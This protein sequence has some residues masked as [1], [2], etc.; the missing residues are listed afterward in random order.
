[1]SQS[2]CLDL[3]GPDTHSLNANVQT[4]GFRN[5]VL[6]GLSRSRKE[7]HCKYFYDERGSQLF[8]QICELPEYYPTRT[9]ASI[10][11]QNADAIGQRIG[12][13]AVLVEYGSGSST[14]TR[15]LLDH[16]VDQ[17]AYLPVDISDEHLLRT[18]DQL[19][20]DYPNLEIDPIVADF[21]I[22]FDLPDAY[23]TTPV[24]VYFPGSTIGNLRTDAAVNLLS[25][26][27]KQCHSGGGLVIGF[28]LAKSPETLVAAY[29][30][31]AGVTAEF[32]LNLLHR[33]NREIDGDFDLDQFTHV[34]VYND[35][36]SRIEIYIESRIE[37]TVSIGEVDIAFA[38][39]E[40][41]FT[42]Y[43]HKYSIEQFTSMAG[44]AGFAMDECWTDED[45]LFAVMHL[46]LE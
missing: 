43:S 10:M 13:N 42:E 25:A 32:N 45:D 33:I 18:A 46:S 21:T 4:L 2:H 12:D 23:Q 34:A 6:L 24:T 14:K 38:E 22:G 28:D 30:D 44:Q 20:L 41:I 26:I 1:M 15:L 40:R 5:D 3:N 31:S 37:Q 8:D 19:R 36:H 39:G 7:L 9:E 29:D 16:L 35:E 17:R 11:R 27:A